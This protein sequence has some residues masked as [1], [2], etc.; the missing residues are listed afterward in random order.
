MCIWYVSILYVTYTIWYAYLHM[1]IIFKVK[2]C[3]KPSLLDWI[4]TLHPWKQTIVLIKLWWTWNEDKAF[5]VTYLESHYLTSHMFISDTTQQQQMN[6][7]IIHLASPKQ[8]DMKRQ[9][10]GDQESL[11][12]V[13][14]DTVISNNGVKSSRHKRLGQIQFKL[15]PI[16]PL[17]Q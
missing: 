17:N 10:I 11:M 14:Q 9:Y 4:I 6:I 3:I 8:S 1:N 5:I 12:K 7:G 2:W 13:V 16:L 15:Q